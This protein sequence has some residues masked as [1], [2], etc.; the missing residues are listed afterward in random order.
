MHLLC[1]P[2]NIFWQNQNNEVQHH[3]FLMLLLY[4]SLIFG[5]SVDSEDVSVDS[6]CLHH[7]RQLLYYPSAGLLLSGSP[8]RARKRRLS[9]YSCTIFMVISA[10]ET[11]LISTCSPSPCEAATTSCSGTNQP[12]AAILITTRC[13]AVTKTTIR[14]AELDP[15]SVKAPFLTLLFCKIDRLDFAQIA[16]CFPKW[17]LIPASH[18][19][20]MAPPSWCAHTKV[21]APVS[22]LFVRA[23]GTQT[24]PNVKPLLLLAL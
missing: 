9:A 8:E 13:A 5:E 6:F 18:L 7:I 3:V 24:C 11:P 21:V 4:I 15:P 19:A 20:P 2:A 17:L 14:A 22:R 10:K 16:A 12:H 23:T 1:S